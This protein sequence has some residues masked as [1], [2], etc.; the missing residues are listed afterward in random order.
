MHG[1][2]T[3]GLLFTFYAS[4]L[5]QPR[6]IL[7]HNTFCFVLWKK[8]KSR[9]LCNYVTHETGGRRVKHICPRILQHKLKQY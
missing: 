2:I 5:P 9:E 1:R 4:A 7:A 3:E 6:A 8:G